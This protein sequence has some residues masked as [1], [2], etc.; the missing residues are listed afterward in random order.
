[1][2]Y[3]QACVSEWS[4]STLPSAI[5]ELQHAPLPLKVLWAKERALTLPSSAIFLLGFTFEPFEELGVR[6]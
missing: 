5:S 3:V 4:L 1:M 2:G 6:Q